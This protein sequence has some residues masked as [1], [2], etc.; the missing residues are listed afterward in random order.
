MNIGAI[1]SIVGTAGLILSF[2]IY[3]W[4]TLQL[5]PKLLL[6]LLLVIIPLVC[7]IAILSTNN[8]PL[9]KIL[10]TIGIVYPS[11]VLLCTGIYIT[12]C[13]LVM[14]INSIPF[15]IF[16]LFLSSLL[17]FTGSIVTLVQL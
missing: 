1:I 14:G 13:A 15:P 5:I 10:A 2:V 16:L 12:A 4:Y 9:T 6:W 17:S 8:I 3:S 7:A 11:F